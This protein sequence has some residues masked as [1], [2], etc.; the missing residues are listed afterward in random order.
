MI[1]ISLLLIA[2]VLNTTPIESKEISFIQSHL[3]YN[4]YLAQKKNDSQTE[5]KDKNKNSPVKYSLGKWITDLKKDPEFGNL[6]IQQVLLPGAHH[7]GLTKIT[8]DSYL[9]GGVAYQLG[10][11]DN[12]PY[13]ND[14][15]L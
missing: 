6:T 13:T 14:S 8:Y 11:L 1:F 9:M 5:P 10:L 12:L 7:A 15:V 3:S 2:V 4:R